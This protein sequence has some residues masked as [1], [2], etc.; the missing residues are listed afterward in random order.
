MLQTSNNLIGVFDSG[1]GGLSVLKKFLSDVPGYRYIY[2]GDNARVPYGNKSPEII[3]S[4]T[5]QAVE[6]LFKQNCHLVIIACNTAS[7][8]ALRRLQ[9]EWLPKH[10]P[11]RR[12]L[13]V[14][15]PLAESAA[16]NNFKKIGVI[17][18]TATI[19][20]GAYPKEIKDLNP[21]LKV[22]GQAAPL[23][24]PLIEDGRINSPET[25][26]ILKSYLA[27]LQAKKIDSLI[28]A[29]T[30]YPHLQEM[31][32]KIMG[33]IVVIPDTGKIIAASLKDYLNR[34]LELKIKKNKTS[35]VFYTTDNPKIFKF[36]AEK[37]LKQKIKSIKQIKL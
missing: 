36:Q 9:Q 10:Y 20:S 12:V 21:K 5:T 32:Q 14:I 33:S 27:P 7:A 29:C 6:F 3:Y 4:Y 30:H 34:H 22:Y 1:L 16:K 18:T 35:C 15:K 19:N 23:L 26:L 13:G 31:I 25:K 8:H 11:S 28:L 24:V 2:L 37:F 17:G